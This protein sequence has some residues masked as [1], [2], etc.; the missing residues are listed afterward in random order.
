MEGSDRQAAPSPLFW[1]GLLH[2]VDAAR[3]VRPQGDAAF[4]QHAAQHV[5][6]R[7]GHGRHGGDAEALEDL[8]SPRVVDAGHDARDLVG[9]PGDAGTK[10]VGVVSACDS[11]QRPGVLG[12]GLFEVVPV[13]PVA[14]DTLARPVR[15]QPAERTGHLVDDGDGVAGVG[16]LNGEAGADSSATYDDYVH[17]TIEHAGIL[18]HNSRALPVRRDRG[19]SASTRP[20]GHLWLSGRQST[21]VGRA[22]PID[23]PVEQVTPPRRRCRDG[24]AARGC[25]E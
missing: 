4:G 17:G 24:D 18:R 22:L 1:Q 20:G 5:V 14:H 10:D 23:R 13:E 11:R 7:P 3:R 25:P 19:L 6:D 2:E 9:L 16:Q 8:R 15:R 12:A 21:L